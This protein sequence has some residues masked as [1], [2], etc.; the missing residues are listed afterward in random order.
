M[1]LQRVEEHFNEDASDYDNHIVKFVPYYLE[2]N[3]MMMELLPFEG[4]AR[5][6]GLDLGAGTGV[7]AEGVLRRYPLAEVTVF[8]LSE[9]MLAAARERLIKF[10]NRITLQKG[11]FSKDDF[12]IGYD[13]ILSGLSIHHL[14]NPRKQELFRRIYLALNPGGV[15]L[16]RDVIKGAT[17]RLDEIYI[18]LWRQYIRSMGED[19]AACMERYYAEDVPACVEDQ[20]EWMRQAGFVDV[21]CHWQRTN[22]AIYGG[23]KYSA[24]NER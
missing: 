8:D 4:T 13:L 22:Y 18:R 1:N 3:E 2:Q 14:S 17:D 21:G 19:D 10:E 24:E 11:D 12:G 16:N 20:L 5:V 15:F 9:N 23:H 7:L 6:R